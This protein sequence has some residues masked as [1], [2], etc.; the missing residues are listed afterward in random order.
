[1]CLARK[2]IHVFPISPRHLVATIKS[3]FKASPLGRTRSGQ[4]TK[5]LQP[6]QTID[7]QKKVE[8]AAAYNDSPLNSKVALFEQPDLDPGFALQKAENQILQQRG[9]QH[10]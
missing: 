10:Y 8:R 2:H 1:M 7:E 9:E 4:A 3:K 5:Q 6:E